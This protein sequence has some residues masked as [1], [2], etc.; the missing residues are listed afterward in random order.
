MARPPGR[1]ELE[2][3]ARLREPVPGMKSVHH[4]YPRCTRGYWVIAGALVVLAVVAAYLLVEKGRSS[5]Q[6][7]ATSVVVSDKSI[8]VLPFVDMSEKKD[9][10]Y[11]ADGMAEEI[12]NLLGKI[13]GLNVISR[14][15]SF[16]FKGKTE[17]LRH[18]RAAR[19]RPCARGQRAQV[20]RSPTGHCTADRQQ[21]QHKRLVANL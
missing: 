11:F 13:P 7:T 3:S 1:I 21:G 18:R 10:E 8:A 12:I 2:S 6:A 15:S 20:G 14:T 16:Q 17:D 4:R 9:Q 19:R 5:K